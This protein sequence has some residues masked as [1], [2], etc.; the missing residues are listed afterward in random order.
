MHLSMNAYVKMKGDLQ[1]ILGRNP[2]EG[3]QVTDVLIV[4]PFDFEVKIHVLGAF[5]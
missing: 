1:G 4:E 3:R 2:L 5:A